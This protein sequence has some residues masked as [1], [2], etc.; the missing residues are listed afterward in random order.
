MKGHSG[1]KIWTKYIYLQNLLN[2]SEPVSL[3]ESLSQK[4]RNW[5][6]EG[7]AGAPVVLPK[8]AEPASIMAYLLL[9]LQAV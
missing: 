6:G 1:P 5:L 9:C 7:A 4:M 2:P 8:V 3:L